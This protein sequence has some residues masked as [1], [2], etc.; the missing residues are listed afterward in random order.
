M[1]KNVTKRILSNFVVRLFVL[2]VIAVVR[3]LARVMSQARMRALAPHAG[4]TICH[5][6]TE[7]KY[8]ENITFGEG[9]LIGTH[10]TIGAA[11]PISFGD[12]VRLSKGVTVETA[13]LDFSGAPPY[14]HV[15]RPIRLED[16]VWIGTGAVILGGVTVGAYSVIGAGA[17]VSRDVPPYSIFTGSPSIRVREKRSL[18][19]QES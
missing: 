5:W 11:A 3:L 6:T 8:P 7:I 14:P 16:G 15:A 9:V 13:G 18:V 10:C 12:H 4:E 1:G 2:A 19:T 17:V